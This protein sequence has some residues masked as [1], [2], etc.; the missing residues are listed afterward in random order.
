M[1]KLVIVILNLFLSE[2]APVVIE[3]IFDIDPI[4]I[5]IPFLYSIVTFAVL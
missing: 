4:A 3:V 1:V 5:S 2:V